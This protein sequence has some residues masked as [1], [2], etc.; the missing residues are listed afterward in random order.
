MVR[1]VSSACPGPARPLDHREI[2][3]D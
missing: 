2:P 3:D 1:F